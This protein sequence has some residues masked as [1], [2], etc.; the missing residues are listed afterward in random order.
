MK[1][2]LPIRVYA[3]FE[4]INQPIR[5]NDSKVV[6][7]QIPVAIG[8]QLTSPFGNRCYSYFGKSC[9]TWFVKE[10][11]LLKKLLVTILKQI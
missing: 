10:I 2:P 8:F 3:D 9:V 6:F 11:L 1:I 5:N 4:C 7:K